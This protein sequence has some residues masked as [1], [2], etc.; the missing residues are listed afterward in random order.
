MMT[1][2][3]TLNKDDAINDVWLADAINLYL[4]HA[5]VIFANDDQDS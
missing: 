5:P 4:I 1:S 3:F 2:S